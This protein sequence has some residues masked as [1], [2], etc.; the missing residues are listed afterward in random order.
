M[1]TFL[2]VYA[3]LSALILGFHLALAVGLVR[4][5]A[6]SRRPRTRSGSTAML[7]AEVIVA[8]RNE[9]RT[10][11]A[12]LESLRVQTRNDAMFLFVDDRSTDAT[13]RLLDEFCAA[14]G[15]RARVIHNTREPQVLTGKQAALDLAFAASRGD[16][17][18]FTDGDCTVAPGWVEDMVGCFQDPAVG[19]AIGRI[20]LETDASFLQRFQA[21]E[22]PL[23][24]QYNLGSVGIG[25]ATGGFG[26]TMAVRAE[27]VRETGGFQVLGYS[28]TEDAMLLDAVCHKAGWKPS[29]CVTAAGAA[30]TIA[31]T[32]WADYVNQHT[33][34][35]A[36]GLFS[37]D[38]ITRFFYVLVVLIYLTGS[39][40]VLPLGILDWRVP[41]LSLT[42]LVSIGMLAA[43][44]GFYEGKDRI[45]Y[46]VPFLPFLVFFAFFYVFVTLRA[47]VWRPF[48]W[49]GRMLSP[50]SSL[51]RTPAGPA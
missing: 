19:A 41:V 17:L 5:M 3:G 27:A 38:P 26:N 39:L 31:K 46:F 48:E 32:R 45:R 49:K 23:L 20:E 12:L 30:R 15:E 16:V 35:N 24:N 37:E 10:L 47:F 44:G 22:Q 29:A 33:R 50:R 2:I 34:W 18:L 28:V 25:L 6:R 51:K 1:Q 40:L 14:E 8:L 11:P 9:E 42:S 7:G 36:G 13:G 43:I 4:N 21:F